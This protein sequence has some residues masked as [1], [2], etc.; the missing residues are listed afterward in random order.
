MTIDWD[1]FLKNGLSKINKKTSVTIG[2][3]DGVHCGHKTLLDRITKYNPDYTP[4]V[5]TFRQ[6][7]NKGS[8]Q[9][10]YI[11]SFSERIKMLEHF[12]VEIILSIEFTDE[13]KK[14]SGL[15]F[16]ELLLKNGNIGFVAVGKNFRCGNNLDTDALAVQNF[17]ASHAIP[18]EILD[19]IKERDL[20]ISSSRIRAALAL[21]DIP[22]AEAMLGRRYL[23]PDT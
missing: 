10:P 22:L 9:V 23:T 6:R 3:F 19:E 1:Q 18:A 17:F 8:K 14:M 11:Q 15:E 7:E 21:G 20:P 5:V 2:V 16:L 13:F 4:M 12:G